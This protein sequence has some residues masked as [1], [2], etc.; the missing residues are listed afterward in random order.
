MKKESL[1]ALVVVFG[2]FG[3]MAALP[4]VAMA[5]APWETPMQTLVNYMTGTTGM[6]LATLG[7]IGVGLLAIAGQISWMHAG[8]VVLAI[9]IIFGAPTIVS[10]F[11]P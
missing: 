10:I 5:A 3:I 1:L 7:V 6:L 9:A 2:A 8:Q 4:H 11:H